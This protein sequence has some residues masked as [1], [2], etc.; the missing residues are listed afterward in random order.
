[1][2]VMTEVRRDPLSGR[3]VIIA[4]GRAARPH[5]LI[6]SEPDGDRGADACPFCPGAERMTPP[7][8]ARTGAGGPGE[9]GWRTR[10]FPNLYPVSDAHEVVVLSPDHHRS[11]A[12]LSDDEA[13][14]V[15]VVC[16]DRVRALV[17]RMPYAVALV[18]HRRAAGASIAHPHAQVVGLQFVPPQVDDT[19]QR[20]EAALVDLV[21]D[22]ADLARQHNLLVD[23][24][25]AAVWC[26]FASTASFQLRVAHP[27]AGP[28]FDAAPDDMVAEVARA[29]RAVLERLR[30]CLEDPP[31][32]LVVH[33]A[34]VATAA[35]PRW[36]VEITPRLGILAGFEQ[37]TGVFVNTVPPEVAAGELRTS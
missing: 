14:E 36:H 25:D 22:D 31:Y 35:W 5:T 23:D 7:E 34:D 28:R 9:P 18:N 32:N 10:V 2:I 20:Q 8:L 37:A 30:T 26:P 16:R 4:A 33:T 29:T 12:Q 11:F 6:A 3:L 19:R 21:D 24:R 17:A 15:M 27:E 13:V 1:V